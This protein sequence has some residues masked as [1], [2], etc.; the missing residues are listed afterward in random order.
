MEPRMDSDALVGVCLGWGSGWMCPPGSMQAEMALGWWCLLELTL[1]WALKDQG[2]RGFVRKGIIGTL[3]G[4]AL[5]DPGEILLMEGTTSAEAWRQAGGPRAC[6]GGQEPCRKP[7]CRGRG[8]GGDT[9]DAAAG[10]GR[11]GTSSK[12]GEAHWP[13]VG[14]RLQESPPSQ[15]QACGGRGG[16]VRRMVWREGGRGLQTV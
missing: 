2:R 14:G 1:T 9:G 13:W 11:P 10:A 8:S 3:A 15:V 7:A 6:S 16:R 4:A 12:L 5:P